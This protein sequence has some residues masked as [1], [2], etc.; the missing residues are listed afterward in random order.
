M[1]LPQTIKRSASLTL[2]TLP[3]DIHHLIFGF[4]DITTSICLGFTCKIFYGIHFY[5]YGKVPLKVSDPQPE[6]HILPVSPSPEKSILGLLKTWMLP[7]YPFLLYVQA[8][9]NRVDAPMLLK[10]HDEGAMA[11]SVLGRLLVQENG[12]SVESRIVESW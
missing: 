2:Q 1:E 4:L 9:Y 6:L 3:Y 12:K 8:A 5:K 10:I 7:R 11:H